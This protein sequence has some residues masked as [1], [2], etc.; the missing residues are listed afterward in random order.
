[1]VIGNALYFIPPLWDNAKELIKMKKRGS[2]YKK[3]KKNPIQKKG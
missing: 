3:L 2:P 1:M